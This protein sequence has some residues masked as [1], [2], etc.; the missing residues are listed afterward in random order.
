MKSQYEI[1]RM[2]LKKLKPHP[3][4]AETRFI[5]DEAKAALKGSLKKFGLLD[6]IIVNK[7]T[8]HIVSGHQR[9]D[10]LLEEGRKTAPVKIID[11]DQKTEDAIFFTLNNPQ[12]AGEFTPE[13]RPILQALNVEVGELAEIVGLDLLEVTIPEPEIFKPASEDEQD[14]LDE[15]EPIVCPNCGHEFTPCRK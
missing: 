11:V 2:S 4:Q 8:N 10:I 14:R 12:I 1:K 13:A 3:Q 5:S 15:K 7:R 9:C 6:D